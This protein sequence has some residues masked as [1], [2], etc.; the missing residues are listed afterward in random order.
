MS[1][2][3]IR[4]FSKVRNF[5]RM[6]L[7]PIDQ[8]FRMVE[9]SSQTLRDEIWNMQRSLFSLEPIT[10]MEKAMADMMRTIDAIHSRIEKPQFSAIDFPKDAFEVGKDGKLKFK[11]YINAKDFKPEDITIQTDKNQLI[12]KARKSVKHGN[13]TMEE[14]VGRSIPIPASV[15]SANLKATLTKDDVLVVEAPVN[16]P[17]YRSIEVKTD[18]NHSIETPSADNRHIALNNKDGLEIMASEGGS[19]T[20]HL[21][22]AVGEYFSPSDLKIWIRDGQV[23]VSGVVTQEEKTENSLR[24]ERHEFCR[25]FEAPE[26]I[27][28]DKLKAELVDGRLAIEAP[29]KP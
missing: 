20:M 5:S 28:V 22:L 10:A 1:R 14:F 12:I 29:I 17:E 6:A 23:Y 21:E 27:D 3:P 15:D 11:V 26:N 7:S 2:L 8:V 13:S 24:S 25:A 19:K 16:E 18:M 4:G 9:R